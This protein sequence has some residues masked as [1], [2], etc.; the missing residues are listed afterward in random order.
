MLRFRVRLRSQ[1]LGCAPLT[2][3]IVNFIL[4]KNWIE[5]LTLLA[6]AAVVVCQILVPPIVGLS[7]N[8]DYPRVAGQ[9]G[10]VQDTPVEAEKRFVYFHRRYIEDRKNVWNSGFVTSEVAPVAVA[11]HTSKLFTEG[12]IFDIRW[13][14][15][16][17]LLLFLTAV[18]MIL[19]SSRQLLWP[20]RIA[21]GLLL[22]FVFCDVGYIA[23]FNSFFSEPAS[24]LFGLAALGAGLLLCDTRNSTLLWSAVFVIS[25]LLFLFAKPQ[26]AP[27]GVLLAMFCVWLAWTSGKWPRAAGLVACA[28]ILLLGSGWYFRA[29]PAYLGRHYVYHAVFW[30]MLRFSPSPEKDLAELKL[31]PALV[32][33]S[34]THVFDPRVPVESPELYQQ[35]FYRISPAKITKF[36]LKHPIRL[37]QSVA[38]T[39]KFALTL[40][41]HYLGNYEKSAGFPP[42]TLSGSFAAWSRFRGALMPANLFFLT[43]VL[44]AA[45][46]IGLILILRRRRS[47]VAA[48]AGALLIATALMSAEQ[49]VSSAIGS[50]LFEV[51]KHLF[52]GQMLFDICVCAIVVTGVQLVARRARADAGVQSFAAATADSGIELHHGRPKKDVEDGRIL[53]VAK[54]AG[55]RRRVFHQQP[56]D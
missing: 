52:L 31:D 42:Q 5:K 11:L 14:G 34:G 39:S 22:L 21:T 29:T 28:V 1:R 32:K 36:Y 8:G 35:F 10:L 40:R 27:L 6:V 17:H 47:H 30:E 19:R 48:G 44:A 50:G 25:S 33:Y 9:F 51:E 54:S 45:C 12:R 46:G 7:D 56:L 15:V 18:W 55:N 38:R 4:N 43:G 16:T 13:L 53:G 23:Y 26:N 37:Y 3:A 49:L 41:P 20:T 24:F 2:V